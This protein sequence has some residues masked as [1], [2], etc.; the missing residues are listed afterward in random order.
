MRLYQKLRI[1][2][3]KMFSDLRAAIAQGY[4]CGGT[5]FEMFCHLADFK[6]SPFGNLFCIR[7]LHIESDLSVKIDIRDG[8]YLITTISDRIRLD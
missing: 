2:Q 7:S 1:S 4:L 6:V 8:R 3:S 5:L